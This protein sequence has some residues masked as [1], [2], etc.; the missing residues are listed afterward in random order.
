MVRGYWNELDGA[1]FLQS[2]MFT[3]IF[4]SFHNNKL[5]EKVD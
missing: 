1:A 3:W 5:D 4:Q 2:N